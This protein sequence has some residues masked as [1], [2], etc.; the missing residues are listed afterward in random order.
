MMRGKWHCFL[1]WYL[2]LGRMGKA[3]ASHDGDDVSWEYTMMRFILL[4]CGL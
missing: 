3:V 2:L 4:V 1:F